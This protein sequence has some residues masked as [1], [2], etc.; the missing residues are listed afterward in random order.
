MSKVYLP[1]VK[2][3]ANWGTLT[4]T[5]QGRRTKEEFLHNMESFIH[6][7]ESKIKIV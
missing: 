3:M 1:S 5:S 2:A 7:L 6:Y 4:E